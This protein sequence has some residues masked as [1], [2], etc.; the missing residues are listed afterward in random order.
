MVTEPF[1]V[2]YSSLEEQ[3]W[4]DIEENAFPCYLQ[5][6]PYSSP[7]PEVGPHSPAHQHKWD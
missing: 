7:H 2:T 4:T 3:P 6:K 1:Q 5:Q